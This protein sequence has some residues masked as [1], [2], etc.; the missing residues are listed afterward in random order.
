[1]LTRGGSEMSKIVGITVAVLLVFATASARAEE[2]KG[3]IRSLDRHER[4]FTLDDGTQIWLAEGVSM[5]PLKE[6]S[7]VNASYEERAGKKV[8]TSVKIPPTR[9]GGK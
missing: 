1:M 8:G 6:G 7:S 9:E 5:T 3:K 4:A 2:I